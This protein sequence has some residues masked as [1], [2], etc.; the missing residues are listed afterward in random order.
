MAKVII[1]SQIAKQRLQIS[2][3]FNIFLKYKRILRI[4][5][6]FKES[7]KTKLFLHKNREENIRKKENPFQGLKMNSVENYSIRGPNLTESL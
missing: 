7:Y 3:L 6:I 2:V 5:D 1:I 4:T